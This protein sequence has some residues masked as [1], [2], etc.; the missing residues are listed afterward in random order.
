MCL[1]ELLVP[2]CSNEESS[3]SILFEVMEGVLVPV[4]EGDCKGE[5]LLVACP[6]SEV[7]DRKSRFSSPVMA[8]D[9]ALNPVARAL[10]N[11]VRPGIA[12]E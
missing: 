12:G 6:L 5:S 2:L 8:S 1:P 4:L 10:V 11:T 3:R 7:G 9:I